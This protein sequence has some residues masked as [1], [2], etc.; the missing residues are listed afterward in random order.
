MNKK[1]SRV[2]AITGNDIVIG[3]DGEIPLR[4]KVYTR[5]GNVAGRIWK[6]MGR[7]SRPYGVF[8]NQA[9]FS[10]KIGDILEIMEKR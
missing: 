7:V 1:I 5:D 10:F 2:V 8:K 9:N 4:S 3:I 6:I